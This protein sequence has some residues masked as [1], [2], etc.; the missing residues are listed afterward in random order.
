MCQRFAEACLGFSSRCTPPW[1]KTEKGR[2]AVSRIIW[3][4][5]FAIIATDL[6]CQNSGE[7]KT[8][9][10]ESSAENAGSGGVVAQGGNGETVATESTTVGECGDMK[11]DELEE[12]DDGN[13][14][15]VD[16]CTT[17]C[18]F[19]CHSDSDCEN[20]PCSGSEVRC[21]TEATHKCISGN[22]R[23]TDGTICGTDMSC[24]QGACL[25]HECGNGVEQPGEECDDG[26]S[27]DRDGCTVTCQY[28]C[29]T[30]DPD[31]SMCANDCDPSATCDESHHKCMPGKPLADDAVCDSGKGYCADGVCIYSECGDGVQQPNEQCDKGDRNGVTDSRCTAQC[32]LWDCGNGIIEGEEQCDDGNTTKLDGCDSECKI[33]MVFR[34][35]NLG[36]SELVNAPAPEW[37]VYNPKNPLN[38]NPDKTRSDGNALAKL[39]TDQDVVQPTNTSVSDMLSNA[40]TSTLYHV[41]DIDDPLFETPDPFV[42]IGSS[43]GR[44]E[45]GFDWTNTPNKLDFPMQVWR[46][47]YDDNLDPI[48]YLYAETIIDTATGKAVIQTTQPAT[49]GYEIQLQ[50]EGEGV[51]A[52]GGT[53]IMR[54]TT[55]RIEIDAPRSQI[56]APP[57]SAHWAK[58]PESCGNF[59]PSNTTAEPTGMICGAI[60]PVIFSEIPFPLPNLIGIPF[61]LSV[62]CDVQ[63]ND[64][65]IHL[66]ACPNGKEDLDA[67]ICSSVLDL[68]KYGCTSSVLGVIL[69]PMGD[70][71][72]D[73]DGDGVYDSYTYVGRMSNQ[74]VKLSAKGFAEGEPLGVPISQ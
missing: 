39:I 56:A 21:D 61:D 11:V 40:E 67:G 63:Y 12:C 57:Q 62:L 37:C 53:F 29:V 74:R 36:S 18:E 71:D 26:N 23:K 34:A 73:T 60:D 15:D 72:A 4:C 30:G 59:D 28:S 13:S 20:D 9:T 65:D 58:F 46:S 17:L 45:E 16:G 66:R 33:E 47:S 41:L 19:T 52:G 31:Y 49:I 50:T 35:V 8:A 22:D 51:L 7:D 14:N 68:F 54:N 25:A 5:F 32:T 42:K 43:I 10:E 48:T 2:V 24:Y 3:I 44:P 27:D 55:L 70:P 38:P 6:G 64:P 1:L 69:N